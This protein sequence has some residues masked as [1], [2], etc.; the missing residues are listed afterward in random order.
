M[1]PLHVHVPF[2]VLD[3]YYDV[4]RER[5]YDLELYFSAA[6]LDQ[7]TQADVEILRKKL[8]WSPA[9]TLH[10]PFMD[11]NPGADEPLV[12]S[13]TQVRFRQ[14]LDVA[15][16]L[17]PRAAVFHAGYFKWR[18]GGQTDGWLKNSIDTWQMVMERATAIKMRVA[19]ENV[20]DEDPHALRLLIDSIKSPDFG[21]CFDT[22]H[23]N[24]FSKVPLETWFESLGK[25]LVEV[26]LHDNDGTAD[27]HRALGQGAIDFENVF[28]LMSRTAARPVFTIEARST[29]DAKISLDRVKSL[30]ST[31][32]RTVSSS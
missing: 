23:V 30:I 27:A 16:L 28:S 6:V 19:V 26:H 14:L 31:H 13:A 20:F 1:E 5:R 24:L 17:K 3:T 2:H 25:H 4:L 15:A 22:G 10:A 8:D 12:R 11:L 32:Y 21:W 29:D 9:L 7:T 18:Y